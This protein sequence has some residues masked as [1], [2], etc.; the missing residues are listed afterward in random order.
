MVERTGTTTATATRSSATH[1]FL[2]LYQPLDDSQYPQPRIAE[3]GRTYRFPFT[4]VVPEQLLPQACSHDRKNSQV[5][6]AHVQP[7]PSLG[8]PMLAGDGK[9]L[10]DDMSPD[11]TKIS[12]LIRARVAK[13]CPVG[14]GLRTMADAAKK[15]RIVPATEEQPPL[16]VSECNQDYCLRKEKDVRRGLLRGKLG[17]LVMEA[18]QPKA[19]KLPPPQT[20]SC[21]PPTTMARVNLRFDPID[22]DQPPP[23]LGTLWSKLKASTFFGSTPWKDFPTRSSPTGLCPSQGV[24]SENVSLSS[25]CVVSAQWQKHRSQSEADL[26]RRDSMYSASSIESATAASASYV[27]Q[28]FYTAS[29]L[30]PITLP[31]GNKAFVPTF[32]SCLVSR[33]YMLD[34]CISYHTPNA[35]IMVPTVFL[36]IPIQIASAGNVGDSD[37]EGD[38]ASMTAAEVERQFFRPRN[39]APPSPEYT[40]T[41]SS[42]YPTA[43][44]SVSS[45]DSRLPPPE[46]SLSRPTANQ[47]S[48]SSQTQAPTCVAVP[49]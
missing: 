17:R 15:V 32:H 49:G 19:L 36:K 22:E 9:S 34:L 21:C 2:K 43:P 33:V 48:E 7:P 45:A 46:Y 28:T 27:G 26:A 35:N 41:S 29:L 23:R 4:F 16:D 44:G 37:S 25:R 39:I 30:V 5:H 8:D 47:E 6:S 20:E 3:T 42:L 31:A 14:E 1:T 38:V 40:V 11:M 12:Y 13:Q 10:L 18:A 24:Y